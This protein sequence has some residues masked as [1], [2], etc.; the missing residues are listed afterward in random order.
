MPAIAPVCI[1]SHAFACT[2]EYEFEGLQV[3]R[4]FEDV[5]WLCGFTWTLR[6][7]HL[8]WRVANRI[9]IS[10]YFYKCVCV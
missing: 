8:G 6:F 3:S 1:G 4:R 9:H 5:F 2:L 7:F 10:M